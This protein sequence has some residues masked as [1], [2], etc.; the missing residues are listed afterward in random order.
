MAKLNIDLSGRGGL[1][2]M[3]GI[4]TSNRYNLREGQMVDGFWSPYLIQ[5]Y[6]YP[7]LRDDEATTVTVATALAS[8]YASSLYDPV[9]DIIYFAELGRFLD[10]GTGGSDDT[11]LVDTLDCGSNYEIRDLGFYQ[12]N[13]VR[14]MYVLANLTSSNTL[15]IFLS[16]DM[17]TGAEY[18]DGTD[19]PVYLSTTV[20]DGAG[21]S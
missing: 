15:E 1:A 6:L 14:K 20:G 13:E 10:A 3:Y 9:G 4:F 19:D 11:S 21:G 18:D 5:G 8:G 7:T 2:D 16:Q 12:K 17:T